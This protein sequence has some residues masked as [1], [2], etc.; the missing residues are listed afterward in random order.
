MDFLYSILQPLQAHPGLSTGMALLASVMLLRSGRL[1]RQSR[2]GAPA[3]RWPYPAARLISATLIPIATGI[4]GTSIIDPGRKVALES[5]FQAQ[6]VDFC[7]THIANHSPL[8]PGG[9]EL[10]L[11]DVTSFYHPKDGKIWKFFN[12]HKNELNEEQF[13][14]KHARVV[15]ISEGLFPSPHKAEPRIR[16]KL[17][18]QSNS[19]F[20]ES[21]T[22][23]VDGKGKAYMNQSPST[24]T[25]EV[26]WPSP[27]ENPKASLEVKLGDGNH[28]NIEYPGAWGLIRLLQAGQIE[29]GVV[30]WTLQNTGAQAL[31]I[32]FDVEAFGLPQGLAPLLNGLGENFECPTSL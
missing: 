25:L 4:L 17:T 23:Q 5:E 21:V 14:K 11:A 3:H 32:A 22:L 19:E 18:P 8:K 6:V 28:R 27:A 26:T 9:E 13:R 20:V 29:E 15:Q 12:E 10:S 24:A 30:H 7:Q 1:G 31:R 16:L 2:A